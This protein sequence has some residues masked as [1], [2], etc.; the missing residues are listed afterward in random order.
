MTE[1][2]TM[3]IYWG[4]LHGHTVLSDGN[5]N[6]ITGKR[7]RR[8]SATTGARIRFHEV[9]VDGTPLGGATKTD[10]DKALARLK[11]EGSAPIVSVELVFGYPGA[12][13][14]FFTVLTER[15]ERKSV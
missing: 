5:Y 10:Q 11:I 13:V 3:Q 14:P 2:K 15:F 6:L 12:A 7:E 8:T 1:T 4:D 9:S